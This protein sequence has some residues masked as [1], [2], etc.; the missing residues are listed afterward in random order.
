MIKAGIVGGAGYTA[1]ELLR[2]LINHPDVEIVFVN[3]NSNA[4]NPITDVHTGLYGET[5]LK[6]TIDG[7]VYETDANNNENS[8]HSGVNGIAKKIWAVKEQTDKKIVF[9]YDAKDLEQ[10]FPGNIHYEVTYELTEKN[11]LAISYYGYNDRCSR[12]CDT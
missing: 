2:L 4:G 7:E 12:R 1:G 11:E 5:D 3:S 8:L 9:T 6:F 10:G